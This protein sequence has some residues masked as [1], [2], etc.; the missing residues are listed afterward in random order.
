MPAGRSPPLL[1][2]CTPPGQNTVHSDQVCFVF[3][4]RGRSHQ[5]DF[6]T[7]E[8]SSLLRLQQFAALRG[9]RQQGEAAGVDPWVLPFSLQAYFLQIQTEDGIQRDHLWGFF[10]PA[11]LFKRE[12]KVSTF[13]IRRIISH[14]LSNKVLKLEGLWT[15]VCVQVAPDTSIQ[16]IVMWLFFFALKCFL[17]KQHSQRQQQIRTW[18]MARVMNV[19]H[20][21]LSQCMHSFKPYNLILNIW[22]TSA[23]AELDPAANTAE[24]GIKS[25]KCLKKKKILNLSSNLDV[26]MENVSYIISSQSW[27]WLKIIWLVWLK[28]GFIVLLYCSAV[29][30]PDLSPLTMSVLCSLPFVLNLRLFLLHRSWSLLYGGQPPWPEAAAGRQMCR[31]PVW[32]SWTPPLKTCAQTHARTCAHGWQRSKC[33]QSLVLQ[34]WRFLN[35]LPFLF[36]WKKLNDPWRLSLITFKA[37]S[38]GSL[39]LTFTESHIYSAESF[40]R[41]ERVTVTYLFMPEF[42]IKDLSK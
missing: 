19:H 21:R 22:S 38:P 9:Q 40:Q 1:L 6:L 25:T 11:W 27:D 13:K 41:H 24:G 7:F 4:K 33:A 12:R 16:L 20:G 35:V 42:H 5:E 29:M 2:C 28:T 31:I 18:I 17:M 36:H 14:L 39:N 37:F 30:K 3:L 15:P 23:S 34:P 32:N 8:P 10:F 26:N